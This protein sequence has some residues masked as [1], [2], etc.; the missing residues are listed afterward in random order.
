MQKI[1]THYVIACELRSAERA[2]AV[3]ELVQ[4]LS[5]YRRRLQAD[6]WLDGRGSLAY[7]PDTGS[8]L[9]QPPTHETAQEKQSLLQGRTTRSSGRRGGLTGGR[10]P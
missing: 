3:G 2:W 1:G 4:F 8:L 7:D 5:D 9:Y 6:A 10:N